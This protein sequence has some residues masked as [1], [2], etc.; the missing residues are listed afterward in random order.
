MILFFPKKTKVYTLIIAVICLIKQVNAEGFQV[1]GVLKTQAFNEKNQVVMERAESFVVSVN[2][3]KWFI[4]TSPYPQSNKDGITDWEIG[5]D[6]NGEIYQIAHHNKTLIKPTTLNDAVGFVE[7]GFVPRDRQGNQISEL[8][9]AFASSCYLSGITNGMMD[10]I[11]FLSDT[12]RSSLELQ[13]YKDQVTYE[14][15]KSNPKLPQQV[16]FYHNKVMGIQ[17]GKL[18]FNPVPAPFG[19]GFIRAEYKVISST[20]INNF[21]IPTEFSFIDNAVVPIADK[22][23][24]VRL[25]NFR[26]VNGFVN[27]VVAESERETCIPQLSKATYVDERRFERANPP[28]AALSYLVTNQIWPPTNSVFLQNLYTHELNVR[29][30]MVSTNVVAESPPQT[31]PK[32]RTLVL[33]CLF[34]PTLFVLGFLLLN[35][36]RK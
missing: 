5:S 16:V 23:K 4:A 22:E 8:W 9:L 25:F 32:Q 2:D 1:K 13:G 36:R 6:G 3:C 24:Q 18:V 17:N 21:T 20:N 28:I 11:Y 34:L 31:S 29:A 35:R 15:F 7:S 14:L 12:L 19:N 30:H 33:I 26:I 27:E 10:P